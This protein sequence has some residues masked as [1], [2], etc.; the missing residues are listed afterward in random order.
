MNLKWGRPARGARMDPLSSS[1]RA[2]N[3]VA[4]GEARADLVI[5]G[6]RL[7][8]VYTG[9]VQ[10]GLDIAVAGQ[11]IAYVGP[12]ASH[13]TGPKTRIRRARGLFAVPGMADPHVH[14]DQLVMPAEFAAR[15]ALR[16]V[17]SL[18]ADPIDVVSVAGARGL[19]EFLR[20]CAGSA[21][22]VF[23]AVPGGLPVDRRFSTARTLTPSQ[24]AAMLRRADVVG[25][26]EVFSWTRVTSRDPATMRQLARALGEG[27]A[28]NGH[29]AGASGKKLQAYVASGILSCHEPVDYAQAIE[30]LRLGMWVMAREGSIRRDLRAIVSEVLARGIDT[31][32]LMFCSDGVNPVDMAAHGHI[33]HCVREAV[34]LGMDPVRAYAIASRNAFDYYAMGR[35]LGGI[36]PGR[37]A[38]IVLMK[39][40]GAARAQDVYVGGREVV[41]GGRL[42]ARAHARGVPAWAARTVRVRRP[43]RARDFEVPARGRGA[44]VNTISMATEIITRM[45]SATLES[46]GGMLATGG[47][48][49]VMRAAALDRSGRT[50]SLAVAFVEGMGDLE[51]AIA[52]TWTFHENDLVVVGSGPAEMAV[53]ARAAA[54]GGGGIAVSRGRRVTARLPMRFCGIA[55]T[56][57]MPEAASRL[58]AIDSEMSAAG[59]RFAR[60]HLV[61]LFLPFLALPAVR[62][63]HSGLVDVRARRRVPAV[64]RRLK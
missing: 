55:S 26:G 33:D 8:N 41:R 10:E 4:M 60:A 49:G 39:D 52:S 19:G 17:T 51:G 30:R 57:P 46:R 45:G 44:E 3:A 56:L 38:D 29:T 34:S 2:L 7:A 13:A 32:R 14:I 24:E 6:T 15:A 16:G 36:G 48:T 62:L 35:D 28:I 20:Q 22:R 50:G 61:P 59:C 12:D 25:L 42:V 58:G 23:G 37:L 54:A 11:R 31:S 40:L 53:A 1:F 18:F 9:E 63:L 64:A 43:I 27:C 21:A 5:A 47:G